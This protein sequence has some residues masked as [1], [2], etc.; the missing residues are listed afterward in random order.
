MAPRVAGAGRPSLAAKAAAASGRPPAAF[1]ATLDEPLCSGFVGHGSY[2]RPSWQAR[3]THER[4][5]IDR[6]GRRK[7]DQY[8]AGLQRVARTALTP[9]EVAA[10]PRVTAR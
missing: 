2:S 6:Q 3:A 1:G 5:A 10:S 4:P 8:V 9:E 7:H